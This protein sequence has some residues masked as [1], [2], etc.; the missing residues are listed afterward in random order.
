MI[1]K[2]QRARIFKVMNSCSWA[3]EG[4]L[5]AR[6]QASLGWP[7]GTFYLLGSLLTLTFPSHPT[8]GKRLLQPK[9]A[10]WAPRPSTGD[11]SPP[12]AVRFQLV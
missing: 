11:V 5:D 12:L 9:Q 4:G 6:P 2:R 10:V 7:P 1:R 3:D 8:A